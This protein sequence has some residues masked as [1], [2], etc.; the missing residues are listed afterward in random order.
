MW[1]SCCSSL[2]LQ[3]ME[4][5]LMPA[6]D[7]VVWKRSGNGLDC[8]PRERWLTRC[9][10]RTGPAAS[11]ATPRLSTRVQA[12]ETRDSRCVMTDISHGHVSRPGEVP[13]APARKAAAFPA[14]RAG[15]AFRKSGFLIRP[16]GFRSRARRNRPRIRTCGLEYCRGLFSWA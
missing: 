13:R 9:G 3:S 16:E 1:L 11:A 6:V 12:R 8:V 2:V 4:H 15:F 7:E 14:R 5:K 10:A